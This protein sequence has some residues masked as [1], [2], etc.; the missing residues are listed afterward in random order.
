MV[1]MLQGSLNKKIMAPMH[2][3]VVAPMDTV[4]KKKQK[5]KE[6]QKKLAKPL[7]DALNVQYGK[8]IMQYI[9]H[10]V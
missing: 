4:E 2:I 9:L 1:P 8:I 3:F 7:I 5:A 10:I 6:E